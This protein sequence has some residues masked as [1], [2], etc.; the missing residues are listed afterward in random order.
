M[1]RF[2]TITKAEQALNHMRRR[3][4]TGELPGGSQVPPERTLCRE[5]ALSRVTINKITSSLVQEG[6]LE[7]RGPRGTYV[8]GQNGRGATL[9]IGFLMQT[10]Q[11]QEVNPVLEAIF[12]AFVQASHAHPVLVSFG[13]AGRWGEHLPASFTATELDALVVA[14]SA[15]PELINSFRQRNRP[16]LFVD[17]TDAADPEHCVTTD[18]TE[19]G[20]LGAKHLLECGR[21]RIVAFTYPEGGY[22]GFELRL[23]G[24]RRA[25][26]EAGVEPDERR[27]LRPWF[28]RAEHIVEILRQLEQNA[29]GFDAFYGFADLTALWGLDALLRMGKRVPE[30][31]AV[32]GIDGLPLGEWSRPAL[33]S[34]AQ[35]VERL[36]TRAFERIHRWLQSGCDEAG[37]ER[38][39]PVLL[40]RSST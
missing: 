10:M 15:H 29:G 17:E 3:I 34:V 37:L 24:F 18:Q 13:M 39:A 27:I 19:A 9:K 12:R 40:L 22:R 7:R 35:P 33:S 36:G 2:E 11:P 5:Y 4:L 6:L 16:L 23:E 21:R 38:L 30:E 1:Q 14:G 31:V 25:H 20:R 32:L 8:V 28:S 26:A